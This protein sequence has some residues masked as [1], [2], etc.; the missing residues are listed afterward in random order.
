MYNLLTESQ[1]LKLSL[2][3]MTVWI[4]PWILFTN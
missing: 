4:K 1:A 3:N 2:H